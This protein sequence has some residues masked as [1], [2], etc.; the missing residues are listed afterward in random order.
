MGFSYQILG[1]FP[2][3]NQ[4]IIVREVSFNPHE[5]I[6]KIKNLENSENWNFMSF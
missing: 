4:N 2:R 5:V 6:L 3:E 1:F